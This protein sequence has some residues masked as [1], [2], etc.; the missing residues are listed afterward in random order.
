MIELIEGLPDNVIGIVAKGRIT[1]SDCADVLLPAI[2]RALEWHHKL[3]LF[4]EIRSRYPGAGWEDIA[5]G[6]DHDG[7]LWERVAIITDVALVRHAL[8]AVRMLIPSDM[9]VFT[10]TQIPEGLAWISEAG[11]TPRTAAP[12][13]Q[14]LRA[15]GGRQF[16]PP[17]QY[18]H[19]AV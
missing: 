11:R 5:L 7:P 2:D 6:I 9:R 17:A 13:T 12:H 18:L 14:G 16:H 19:Q 3:R 10:A 4:Y 8:Q 15:T 1:K